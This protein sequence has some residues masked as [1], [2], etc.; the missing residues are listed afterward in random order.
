MVV[1]K[2]EN[3]R[4]QKHLQEFQCK[5]V[6]TIQVSFQKHINMSGKRNWVF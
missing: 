5:K 1:I 2:F 3:Y 4:R 6:V